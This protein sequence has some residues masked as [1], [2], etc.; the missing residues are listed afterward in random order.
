M[1]VL[2]ALLTPAMRAAQSSSSSHQLD[3]GLNGGGGSSSSASHTLTSC[4]ELGL[5]GS[6]SSASHSVIT[7]CGAL[8]ASLQAVSTLR[9][10]KTASTDR[11]EIGQSFDYTITV[12]NSGPDPA[13]G[14]TVVDDLPEGIV[15]ESST[16]T[17]GTGC[18]ESGGV[19]T[20]DLGTIGAG[21]EA[22]ATLTVHAEQIGT[23]T[24]EAMATAN[25]GADTATSGAS[26]PVTA[27]AVGDIPALD[28]AMLALF[29][30]LLACAGAALIRRS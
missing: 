17:Q 21:A 18:V 5:G 28:P 4:L 14:V 12:S 3:A 2:L 19:V 7:G 25:D 30:V 13:V 9:V 29:A 20:C 27:L 1:V 6:S 15:Y 23:F 10:T 24:N 8:L 22:T 16:T 11:V 26:A